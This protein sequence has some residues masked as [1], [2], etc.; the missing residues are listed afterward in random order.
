MTFILNHKILIT[1]SCFSLL[2]LLSLSCAGKKQVV[3]SSAGLEKSNSIIFLNYKVNKLADG[4]REV[5]YLDHVLR[6]GRLKKHFDVAGQKGDLEVAQLDKQNRVLS[7][8]IIKNPL[9]KTL[10]FVDESKGFQTKTLDLGEALFSVR[11]QLH[12]DAR[13]ISI[14]HFSEDKMLIQTKIDQE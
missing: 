2:F 6:Q 14:K 13:T 5:E 11:M 7:N 8:M 1:V 3:N 9:K 12:P 4:K 10:E